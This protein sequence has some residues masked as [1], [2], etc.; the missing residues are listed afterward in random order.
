MQVIENLRHYKSQNTN[1][2]HWSMARQSEGDRKNEN[3]IK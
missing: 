3:D 2:E 1:L